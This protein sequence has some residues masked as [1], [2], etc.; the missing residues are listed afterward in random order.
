[1]IFVDTS[2]LL[3]LADSEDKNHRAARSIHDGGILRG[4]Y[5]RMVTSDYVLDEAFTLLKSTLGMAA[6]ENL[7]ASVSTSKSVQRVWVGPQ[8]FQDALSMMRSHADKAWSF[9]DCTSFVIMKELGIPRA[10]TF[11]RDFK[12]A[13]FDMV[14]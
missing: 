4:K 13:G 8:H 3:A 6:V 2:A 14:E 12:Q 10:F 5:G 7:A 9:T 1:M 11:D